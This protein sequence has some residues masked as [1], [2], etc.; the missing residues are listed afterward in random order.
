MARIVLLSWGSHGDVLPCVA[1]AHALRV[2][3]HAVLIRP[4]LSMALSISLAG[5]PMRCNPFSTMRALG[6][7]LCAQRFFAL[8]TFPSCT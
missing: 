2:A 4:A 7:A 6:D 5:F 8:S 3:G 1:L